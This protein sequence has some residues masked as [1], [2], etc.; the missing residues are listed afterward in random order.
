MFIID[1]LFLG[2]III[3]VIII[4]SIASS[5]ILCIVGLI[6][7][8]A[9]SNRSNPQDQKTLSYS[10]G[11]GSDNTYYI[12][13]LYRD[14]KWRDS[15]M[16]MICLDIGKTL[17]IGVKELTRIIDKNAVNNSSDREIINHLTKLSYTPK[18]AYDTENNFYKAQ[19]KWETFVAPYINHNKIIGL[20]DYGGGE[21]DMAYKLGR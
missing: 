13:N 11:S 19:S 17:N 20:L 9:S 2:A 4:L 6:A 12:S 1:D 16:K 8:C 7:G 10:G 18:K 15:L 3:C 5:S 14:K 21:G